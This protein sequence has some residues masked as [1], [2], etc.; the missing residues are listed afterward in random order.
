MTPELGDVFVDTSYWIALVVKQDQHHERA[1]RWSLRITGRI[2]TT[3][4]VLLETANTLSRP[5]WRASAAALV[6]HLEQRAD[7]SVVPLSTD[8]WNRGWNLYRARDDKAW[9][10][11]DCISFLAMQ[12]AGLHDAL[13]ADDHFRQAGFRAVLLDDE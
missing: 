2:V 11:T 1:Q 12:E 3:A 5:A 6:D 7:V 8:L 9:S 10:L 13:T 4:A